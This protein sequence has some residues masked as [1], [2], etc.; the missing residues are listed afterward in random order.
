LIGLYVFD[1]EDAQ[2]AAIKQIG[3]P[4]SAFIAI[5]IKHQQKEF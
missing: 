4:D 3:S 2:S 5:V 1:E